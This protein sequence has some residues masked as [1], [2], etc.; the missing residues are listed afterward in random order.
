MGRQR[1]E[2]IVR[3]G[4]IVVITIMVIIVIR[5]IVMILIILV[6][7]RSNNGPSGL[8]QRPPS[9]HEKPCCVDVII[10]LSAGMWV[11]LAVP[12]L[13]RAIAPLAYHGCSIYLG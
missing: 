4:I 5:I 10:F 11:C 9:S 2:I 12:T 13:P 7:V 8:G 6:V 3:I 1:A